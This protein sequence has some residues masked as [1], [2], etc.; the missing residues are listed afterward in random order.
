MEQAQ[1]Q[2]HVKNRSECPGSCSSVETDCGLDGEDP[3]PSPVA[4]SAA[5]GSDS[6][7]EVVKEEATPESGQI[8]AAWTNL[9]G[10]AT[11]SCSS[12]EENGGHEEED[13]RPSLVTCSS[14]A[15]TGS[16]PGQEPLVQEEAAL[17]EIPSGWIRVK[18]EPDC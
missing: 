17:G 5:I 7:E 2:G 3:S 8:M 1:A 13:S 14:S 6:V 16:Y 11:G 10:N 12:V 15:L 9:R 4:S 18:L